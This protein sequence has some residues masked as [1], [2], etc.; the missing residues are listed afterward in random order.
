MLV[1]CPR[2]HRDFAANTLD[3]GITGPLEGVLNVHEPILL[4]AE[5]FK[6][7]LRCF[8]EEPERIVW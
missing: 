2:R 3:I 4:E 8:K 1:S 6:P 7:L 5:L